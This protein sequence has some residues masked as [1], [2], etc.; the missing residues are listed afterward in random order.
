[1]ESEPV[2]VFF[3]TCEVCGAGSMATVCSGFCF[4]VRREW[5]AG[6]FGVMSLRQAYAYAKQEA[7]VADTLIREMTGQETSS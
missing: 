2:K 1:M 3:T 4:E 6:R 7:E 5:T